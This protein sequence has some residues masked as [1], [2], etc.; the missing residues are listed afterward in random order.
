MLLPALAKAKAKALQISCINNLKQITLFAQLYTDDNDD[1]YP[2]ASHS[3]S[4]GD[5]LTNW[6]GSAIMGFSQN[7]SNLFHC[8]TVKDN[9][10]INGQTWI[11]S[12]NFDLVG[13]G[14]NSF[15]LG[16]LPQPPGTSYSVSGYTFTSASGF[17][18]TG[19]KHPS[20]CLVFGDK[21]PKPDLTASG[22]L[23]WPKGSMTAV[24][25][26]HEGIDTTRHNKVG[27]VGFSDG[28][29]EAKRDD[30]IN[31]PV[32]PAAGAFQALVNS[33]YWDPKQAAGDR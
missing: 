24:G 7:Q 17:K 13:Y 29:A 12:F 2:D 30:N 15:F 16:S 27:C 23:W 28:H 18:R 33:K 25:G 3:Y 26:D 20:D 19:I 14:Y 9:I 11:W 8:P 31:P 5:K 10:S 4:A 22:S 21:Q 32:D 6:W 1:K